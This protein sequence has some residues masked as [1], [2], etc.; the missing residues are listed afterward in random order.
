[1]AVEPGAEP[2]V[3]RPW[4]RSSWERIVRGLLTQ[5]QL[6]SFWSELGRYLQEVRARATRAGL[7]DQRRRR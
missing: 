2:P 5:Q 3:D 4:A 1:M 7:Q 6:R